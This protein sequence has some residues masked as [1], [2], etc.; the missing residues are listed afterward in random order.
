M[1]KTY[2]SR[3][4]FF[5]VIGWWSLL[6]VEATAYSLR[7]FSSKN[8]LSNSAILSI[9]QDCDGLIWI[10]SCDG[11]NVFDGTELR[12]Y[13]PVDVRNN[14]SG[15]L[16]DNIMEAEDHV[17]WIQTNYG[18]DRFDTHLQTVQRFK[19]FQDIS[20]MAKT[21]END[22]LVIKDDGYIY[23]FDRKGLKFHRLNAKRLA[24]EDIQYICVDSANVL[25]IFSSSGDVRSYVIEKKED[26]IPELILQ[27]LF[28]Q[29]GELFWTSGEGDLVYF[30]DGAYD[31]YEY[32]LRSRN[33]YF[34]ADLKEEI[35]QRGQV[36]SIVKQRDDYYVGFKSSGL[37]CLKY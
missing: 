17:L 14:L 32:D 18:L 35:A 30:I 34:I 29:E 22:V 24:F 20:C 31:L 27:S 11:L 6:D 25:W 16:I 7:Q 1:G 8:G 36:S 15:N 2:L 12:L 5:L 23:Y 3:F 19:D 13:K 10:G 28:E 37:I 21:R 26:S 33:K 9:C 4:F